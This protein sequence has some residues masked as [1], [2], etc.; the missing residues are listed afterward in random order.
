MAGYAFNIAHL[1]VVSRRMAKP[2]RGRLRHGQGVARIGKIVHKAKKVPFS[3]N[4]QFFLKKFLIS[5]HTLFIS[6][7]VKKVVEGSHSPLSDTYSEF[8]KQPR[9]CWYG[10]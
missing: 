6:S 7:S 3:H 8:S 9:T 5:E 1:L 4:F 2:H 10:G